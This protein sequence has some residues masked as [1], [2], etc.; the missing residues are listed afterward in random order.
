MTGELDSRQQLALGALMLSK[1]VTEAAESAGVSERSLRRWIAEDRA[2]REAYHRELRGVMD[3]AAGR[4]QH[5]T[6]GA[7]DA[8][9]SVMRD[10]E[11]SASARAAAARTILE[12]AFR[13]A[14]QT[15]VIERLDALEA[16]GALAAKQAGVGR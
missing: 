5:A 14:E 2:F 6:A 10:G 11:A 9:E 7:L 1:T 8:L 3:H 12:F 15:H 13:A 16:A 4:L